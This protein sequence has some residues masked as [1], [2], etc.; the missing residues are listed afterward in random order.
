MDM[1]NGKGRT[2]DHPQ[3]RPAPPDPP[4][5]CPRCHNQRR[6][7]KGGSQAHE[8]SPAGGQSCHG[9]NES[10]CRGKGQTLVR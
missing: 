8:T 4:G 1:S 9:L 2:A 7:S 10:G 3:S 5:V 6:R